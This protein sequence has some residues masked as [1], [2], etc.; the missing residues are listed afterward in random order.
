VAYFWPL[1][2]KCER[3]LVAF[4]SFLS[5]ASRLEL[6][7]AVLTALPT[8]A[9]C[10]FLLPKTIIKQ[11]D[12]YRKH[13][14]WRD[15]DINNKKPPKAAWP[16]VTLPKDEGGLGVLNLSVQNESLLMKHLHKFFNKAQIPWVQLVWDKY[17]ARGKLSIQ[18][19]NF[20]GSF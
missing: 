2:L 14:L 6:T 19:L 10:T 20:R 8:Y 17:Y 12:K 4:S 13:C 5:E 16:M 15:A 18:S 1:V 11:I 9:M 7:Y 3:R